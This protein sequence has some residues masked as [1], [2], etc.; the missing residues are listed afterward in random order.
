MRLVEEYMALIVASLI[1]LLVAIIC[2]ICIQ[3]FRINTKKEFVSMPPVI[4]VTN[5][6][7][8]CC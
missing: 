2:Y 4:D 7:S 1:F 8:D 6:S 3:A 5:F